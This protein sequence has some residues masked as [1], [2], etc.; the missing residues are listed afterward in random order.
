[1][2]P[3][4]ITRE[5]KRENDEKGTEIS[6][7]GPDPPLDSPPAE[8]NNARR[9]TDFVRFDRTLRGRA[10]SRRD[11]GLFGGL[12][13]PP[14]FTA[15]KCKT[16]L[17]LCVGRI[18]LLQNKKRTALASL[19]RE[20]ADLLRARKY[21]SAR[22]RVEAVLREEAL[23]DAFEVLHLHCDLLIV[24]VPLIDSSKDLPD[25]LRAPVATV[26]YAA[27][28]TTEL[29]ELHQIASQFAGKYGREYVAACADDATAAACGVSPEAM[30]KL[31]TAPPPNGVKVAK[32]REIA[33]ALCADV[34]VD[35]AAFAGGGGGGAGSGSAVGADPRV[36]GSFANAGEAARA[37][38]E[39]ANAAKE[40]ADRAAALAGGSR[41]DPG[42]GIGLGGGVLR[43]GTR[44][45]ITSDAPLP[46]PGYLM[47]SNGVQSWRVDV[48]D[49]STTKGRSVSEVV[50]GSA[51][52]EA[53]GGSPEKPPPDG[54]AEK[55]SG[56][57]SPGG[58]SVDYVADLTPPKN[59]PG[60]SAP[61]PNPDPPTPDYAKPSPPP[62]IGGAP[63]APSPANDAGREGSGPSP[64]KGQ[65][66][67]DESSGEAA[68]GADAGG[69]A[70]GVDD[71]DD[72]ASRFEA[73]KRR[74]DE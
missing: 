59:E 65:R 9:G 63:A 21:D 23:L 20:I 52:A 47:D 53:P 32:L 45:V 38:R 61:T 48:G 5:R 46:P 25:D 16:A 8:V 12:F 10:P 71:F 33:D 36:D 54:S 11:M 55:P 31:S 69:D 58:E 66:E 72:L 50:G 37:A 42:E 27:R 30:A 73:L 15:A 34:D 40:A 51:E 3:L 44:G 17:R 29:P 41:G 56:A 2:V 18:K 24:R 67:A 64:A 70:R 7:V 26:T 22:V 57:P 74:D 43:E 39:A 6:H 1:M 4:P 28:R 49:V 19:R 13:G 35:E 14:K 62:G 68:E 60:T